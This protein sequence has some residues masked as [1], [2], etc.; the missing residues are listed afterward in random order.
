[1]NI[2][3]ALK[4]DI[5]KIISL[6]QE[7]YEPISRKLS[8]PPGAITNTEDKALESFF[9][10]QL[11]VVYLENNKIIGTFS[12]KTVEKDTVK[13]SHLAISPQ[14][15]NQGI[16]SWVLNEIITKFRKE[17]SSVQKITLEVYFKTP[18]LLQ[19]Y[20]NFD[21]AIVGEKEI[22]GE[23]ILILSLDLYQ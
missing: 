23:R 4:D 19:F 1:L 15:Q 14:L 8:R 13:L 2:K 17:E 5:P 22:R 6:I 3:I 21:F 16:G 10:N 20:K 9:Q 18:H 12:L 11:Y 7:A